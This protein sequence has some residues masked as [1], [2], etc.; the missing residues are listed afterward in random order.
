MVDGIFRKCFFKCIGLHLY[1]D[2]RVREHYAEE[3]P[4]DIQYWD[5]FFPSDITFEKQPV[6][7]ESFH[8]FYGKIQN[9]VS[10]F[11]NSII[12]LQ[13]VCAFLGVKVLIFLDLT[14]QNSVGSLS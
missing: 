2:A 3:I 13:A 4:E 10:V 1:I 7:V 12:S 8:K 11:N 6:D 14:H 9:I 5:A